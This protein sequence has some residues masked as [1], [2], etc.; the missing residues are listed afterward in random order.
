MIEKRSALIRH[1]KFPKL[2]TVGAC[3]RLEPSDTTSTICCTSPPSRPQ[4]SYVECLGCIN[5]I[6]PG[7]GVQCPGCTHHDALYCSEYCLEARADT[8]ARRCENPRRP[9]TTADTLT[10]AAYGDM[11][12]EDPQTNEDYFFTRARTTNDKTHLLG[13]YIGIIKIH[14]VNPS[15]LHGWRTSG[16]MVE[17]IKALYE[18]IPAG[19]RGGYYA[20]FLKNV[21]IFEPR[22]TAL[23]SLAPRHL[24]GSC[25]VSANVRCSACKKVWYCSQNCQQKDWPS[26]LVDC[27]PGRPITSAD[28]LRAAAHRRKLFPDDLEKLSDYGFTR[29]D[30]VGG[31][32]LLD[33]YRV[34]FDEGVRSRDLQKWKDSGLLL[35]EVEKLLRRLETWKTHTV[36][37][38]FE[39][40][41]HALDPALPVPEDKTPARKLEAAIVELWKKV[42]DFPSQNMDE[43]SLAMRTRWSPKRMEFFSFRAMLPEVG[44]PAP[45][46]EIWVT[47]GFCA[48][49]DESEE[50]FLGI[51]YKILAGR[52]S[53]DEFCTAYETYTIIQLLDAKELRGR[54][55]LLPYLE[56]ALS[57]PTRKSVWYL[58]QHTQDQESA[59]SSMVPALHVD[60][61]FMNCTSETEY[62]DLKAM[63]KGIFERRDANP[64]KLHEACVSG[65]LYEYAL[66]L[67]PELKNKKNRAKKFKRLMKNP[68]PL[69]D[70][71]A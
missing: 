39:R 31:K 13:L 61:G 53:Y 36:M 18:D 11:F 16:T 40:H 68:Y 6:A 41:R 47:F 14:E 64:L 21:D 50:S 1:P 46:M 52:C 54:R 49:H 65:A 55:M 10:A 58:K 67:F 20:W 42:G 59:R 30:E 3:G 23:V 32:M 43:I 56:D 35:V 62:Q 71:E 8:H 37:P 34:V 9:L 7:F 33:V 48:C 28:H 24:C 69:A 15:K 22:S 27:D 5:E 17:N 26:H 4:M 25:G 2:P 19:S 12:P 51:T 63:Y 45:S 66:G 57:G 60:Y 70:P 44:H 29:V 38:W